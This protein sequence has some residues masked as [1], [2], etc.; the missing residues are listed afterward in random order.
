ME[1]PMKQSRLTMRR[2]DAGFTL[3]ELAVVMIIFGIVAAVGLPGLNKF[4]RSLDLNGEVQRTASL[5]RVTRQRAVT[6][7][8]DYRVYWDTAQQTFVWFDDDNND[9]AKQG[10]EKYGA[11]GR[12]PSWITVTEVST[13]P[14]TADT[15]VFYPNGSTNTSGSLQYSNPDGYSRSLSV[16]RPT[17]M[18]T[19]Q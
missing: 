7:N 19:V 9:G 2:S 13:N 8:N 6:E 1:S 11:L 5:L 12:Y 4:L 17:G 15:V 18:V 3:V 16:V 14:F 10:T